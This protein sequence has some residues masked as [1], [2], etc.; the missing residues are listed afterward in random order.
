MCGIYSAKVTA[1]RQGEHAYLKGCGRATF[2]WLVPHHD[3]LPVCLTEGGG[4]RLVGRLGN[5]LHGTV[6][7]A[8]CE[9]TQAL[10]LARSNKAAEGSKPDQKPPSSERVWYFRDTFTINLRSSTS[11]QHT[12]AYAASYYVGTCKH[13]ANIFLMPYQTTTACCS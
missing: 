12:S 1:I 7:A 8:G 11:T 3:S 2:I 13:G 5:R 4:W 10:E 9:T 6:D